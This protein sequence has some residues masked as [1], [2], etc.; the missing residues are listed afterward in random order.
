MLSGGAERDQ[1]QEIGWAMK[2][3]KANESKTVFN[4]AL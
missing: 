1:L 2:T 3:N 4:Q